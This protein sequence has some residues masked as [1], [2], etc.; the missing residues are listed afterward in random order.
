MTV[1]KLDQSSFFG[2]TPPVD[3]AQPMT[4]SEV[5]RPLN[6]PFQISTTRNAF[7]TYSVQIQVTATI[8]GGQDGDCFLEIADDAA[9]TQNVQIAMVTPASQ[10]YSLAVA[11]QG[12]AKSGANVMGMVPAG[13]WARIRTVNNVGSPTWTFRKGQEMLL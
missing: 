2:G 13:K 11:L 7:A 8:A 3:P 5:T 4:Q 10:T 12:V 1:S 6:T 9:F